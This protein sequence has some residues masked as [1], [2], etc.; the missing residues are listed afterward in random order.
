MMVRVS[1]FSLVLACFAAFGTTAAHA[2]RGV[3]PIA[4]P[5]SYVDLGKAIENGTL[6][7]D[8]I[9]RSDHDARVIL[10][11]RTAR[12]LRLRFPEAF[13]GVPA[14]VAQ[15]FGGGGGGF[16]GGGQGGGGGSQG[17]GGGGG[18][19]GGGGQGGGGGGLFSIPPE[20][21]SKIDLPVVCLDYGKKDPSSSKAYEMV[22]VDLYVERP[23]VVELLKAFGRGEL[24]HNATQAAVWALN[25]D[26]PWAELAA[27]RKGTPRDAYRPPYFTQKEIEV[28][29]AYA[30]EAVRRAKL[31]KEESSE[32]MSKEAETESDG[33]A[34]EA[35][36]TTTDLEATD[37]EVTVE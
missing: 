36:D 8:F 14:I 23:E 12:E 34:G 1:C 10:R 35:T 37:A 15:N 21:V 13:A 16:G 22:D 19:L 6:E 30:K 9:A 26:V 2:E 5:A 33:E 32:S 7:M 20:K 3:P 24:N 17:V 11:N 18:G 29:I 4:D 25:N 31:V 27:K 28:G